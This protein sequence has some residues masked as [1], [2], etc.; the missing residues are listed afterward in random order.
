MDQSFVRKINHWIVR[1][2]K[3]DMRALESLFDCTK[4]H[5][6]VVASAYLT[7][8]D[9][10]DDVVSETYCRVVK[11]AKSFDAA[12][13]GYCWLY[14]IAKNLAYNQNRK[15]CRS[16]WESL[17]E[18]QISSDRLIDTLLDRMILDQA[19]KKLDLE[20]KRIVFEYYFEGKSVAEIATRIGK[21]KTTVYDALRRVLRKMRQTCETENF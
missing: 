16:E 14:Q 18:T 7:D 3:G 9:K 5:V 21:P 2:A 17:G 13:N 11:Y 10:A 6:Y 12:K 4:K 20:E 8:K 15:D 1:I 19:Y